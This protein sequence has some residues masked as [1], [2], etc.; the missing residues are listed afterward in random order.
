MA[1][2]LE[3][4]IVYPLTFPFDLITNVANIRVQYRQHGLEVRDH[5]LLSLID[6]GDT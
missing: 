1:L 4:Q 2:E 3:H 6:L 5:A